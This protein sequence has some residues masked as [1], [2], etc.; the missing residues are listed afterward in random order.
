MP[1]GAYYSPIE[2]LRTVARR[3]ALGGASH[4]DIAV[5]L[6]EVAEEQGRTAVLVLWGARAL[7]S[8]VLSDVREEIKGQALGSSDDLIFPAIDLASHSEIVID[9]PPEP[10]VWRCP[11]AVAKRKGLETKARITAYDFPLP[12]G[13][14]IGDAGAE[15]LDRAIEYYASR[16]A[17][18]GKS[19]RM[20]MRIKKLF[21]KSGK[22]RVE[23]GIPEQALLKLMKGVI[24]G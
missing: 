13:G 12:N 9:D 17:G 4:K 18:F 15:D 8:D 10:Q 11:E 20:F 14:R 3:M 6:V 22:A 5:R 1:D 19:K 23:E 21:L 7:A 2:E 16:E 24:P